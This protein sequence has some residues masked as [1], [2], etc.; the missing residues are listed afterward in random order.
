MSRIS[1]QAGFAMGVFALA[2]FA[3]F[4]VFGSALILLLFS[5]RVFAVKH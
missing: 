3:S 2:G 1:G 5:S 4:M